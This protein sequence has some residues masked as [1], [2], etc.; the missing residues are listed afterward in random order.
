MRLLCSASEGVLNVL[1][2]C[3]VS[4]ACCIRLLLSALT[5]ASEI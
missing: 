5:T 2:L 4:E 3:P 1:L